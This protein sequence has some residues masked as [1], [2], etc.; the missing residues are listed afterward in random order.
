MDEFGYFIL[1]L[2]FVLII[3]LMLTL[4]FFIDCSFD[5]FFVASL[6]HQSQGCLEPKLVAVLRSLT[7]GYILVPRESGARGFYLP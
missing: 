4:L 1:F 7:R 2:F 3:S 6:G 5:L